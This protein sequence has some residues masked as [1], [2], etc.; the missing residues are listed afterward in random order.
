MN[1][2]VSELAMGWFSFCGSWLW[3]SSF[4]WILLLILLTLHV[5]AENIDKLIFRSSLSIPFFQFSL[6]FK[7]D[8]IQV[9][10]LLLKVTIL[11]GIKFKK[12]SLK[13]CREYWLFLGHFR[14]EINFN[15]LNGLLWLLN[16]TWAVVFPDK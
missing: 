5:A 8:V 2:Y 12:Y 13:C 4:S 9:G 1:Q 11:S 3:Y 6:C 15:Q 7:F 14:E 10:S 16:L